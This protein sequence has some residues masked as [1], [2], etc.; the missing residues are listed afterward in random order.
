MSQVQ[1]HMFVMIGVVATVI[2]T[3]VVVA[4]VVDRAVVDGACGSNGIVIGC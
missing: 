2:L 1:S 3:V 4:V